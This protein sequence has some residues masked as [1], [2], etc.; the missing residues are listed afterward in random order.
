MS[1]FDSGDSG[2]DLDVHS[3]RR[4]RTLRQLLPPITITEQPLPS[5]ENV[6]AGNPPVEVGTPADARKF[7]DE[8]GNDVEADIGGENDDEELR[9]LRRSSAYAQYIAAH[10]RTTTSRLSGT[11]DV[12]PPTSGEEKG[13]GGNGGSERD[14]SEIVRNEE[15]TRV[16]EDFA[17]KDRDKKECNADDV[18]DDDDDDETLGPVIPPG[19]LSSALRAGSTLESTRNRTER[20]AIDPKI[21]DD[22]DSD[23]E[24]EQEGYGEGWSLEMA[25]A[26]GLP[27]S[28]E[29][30]LG[31]RHNAHVCGLS[32]DP[33]GSR[34]VSAAADAVLRQWEFNAMD[35]RLLSSRE[36][37]PLGSA[38]VI[39]ARFSGTGGRLLCAG[40]LTVARMLDREGN[41]LLESCPGDMYIVDMARTKGHVAQLRDARWMSDEPDRFATVA[42][43]G[44]LRLWDA[45]AATAPMSVFDG[46][47]PRAKQIS[48]VKL[49]NERGS[50]ANATA[51]AILP[52]E[53]GGSRPVALGCDDCSIK[54]IDPASFSLHPA[55]ENPRAISEG[56]LF[57]ALECSPPASAHASTLLLARSTDDAL[58]VFD[59]RKLDKPL[60]TF[61]ALPNVA[62]QTGVSFVGDGAEW[63]ATGTSANRRGG[64]DCARIQVF[65]TA[66]LSPVWHKTVARESGSVVA[67]TWQQR[68]NQILYGCA[69][70]S[71][72]VMYSSERSQDGVLRCVGRAERRKRDGVVSLEVGEIYTPNALPMFRDATQPDG[73]RPGRKRSRTDVREPKRPDVP[74]Q[75]TSTF[76]KAFMQAKV[77]K[78]WADEDPRE[79]LLK[80]DEA[81]RNNPVF[82]SAYMST[83]PKPMFTDKT[84]E[85]E[86]EE[87]R[88]ALLARNRRARLDQN[89]SSH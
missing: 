78:T 80:L 36:S 49:R 74:A 51:M 66:A 4:R 44:T 3:G 56:A 58:R 47:L 30:V 34:L 23:S 70:G 32:L 14:T 16:G 17:R 24:S 62:A 22:S 28:D 52:G 12:H 73:S 7:E 63:F 54:I 71:I 72:H 60:A 45:V 19:M 87:A 83:Q 18:D 5:D 82:T 67:I 27:V 65:D 20:R 8:E 79:A 25:E 77:K 48:V 35:R 84:A 26:L 46:D 42:G 55:A 10:D 53:G 21:L 37:E 40:G 15:S 81:T 2:S 75:V 31:N 13:R 89:H 11:S 69:D 33:A 64:T 1:A 86:Q 59:L 57:T 38:P 9:R 6:K 61:S 41:P 76:T 85:E 88:L 29:V 39:S 43:D 50:R 68:I